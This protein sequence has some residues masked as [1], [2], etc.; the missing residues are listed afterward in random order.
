[1]AGEIECLARG[2]GIRQK[3][4]EI[5]AKSQKIDYIKKMSVRLFLPAAKAGTMINSILLK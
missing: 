1:V 4:S 3:A 5:L 2:C